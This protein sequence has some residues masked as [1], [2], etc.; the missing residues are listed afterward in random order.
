MTRKLKHMSSPA[1]RPPPGG[2]VDLALLIGRR[3]ETEDGAAFEHLLGDEL[4]VNRHLHRLVCDL[5]RE[6][7][8]QYDGSVRLTDEYVPSKNQRTPPAHRSLDVDPHVPLLTR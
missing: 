1:F 3:I 7:G 2:E 6:G 4:L 5:F 8:G